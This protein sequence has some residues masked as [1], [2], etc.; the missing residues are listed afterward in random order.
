MQ[1]YLKNKELE[2]IM[3][4]FTEYK[5]IKILSKINIQDVGVQ[6]LQ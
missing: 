1:A 2:R 5:D 6:S 3:F 4:Y